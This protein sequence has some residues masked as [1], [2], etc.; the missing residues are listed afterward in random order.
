VGAPVGPL[1]LADGQ[2]AGQVAWLLPLAVVGLGIAARGERL[3]RPLGPAHLTLLLWSAWTLTYAIVYSY[4]GGIFHFYYLATLAPPLAALAGIGVTRLWRCAL[5]NDWRRALVPAT[6]LVTAAWQ[7]SVDASALGSWHDLATTL[8]VRQVTGAWPSWLRPALAGGV[9]VAGG[10][11]A[12]VALRPNPSG[13]PRVLSAAALGT[14]LLATLI[15]PAAWALS[16]VLVPGPGV[17]PSADLARLAD[18]ATSE[19]LAR[20][21]QNADAN[22]SRLIRFLEANRG[23]ARYLLATSSAT[24]ASPIIVRT[25][26]AV[27]ARGGFHGL[28]PILTPEKLARMA[29]AKEVRF[30]MLGDL[31]PVSRRM[32]AEIAGRPIADW[33]RANGRLVPSRLWRAGW[34]A[35]M[36]LYDLHPALDL[37]PVTPPS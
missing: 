34:P 33:V 28:D 10:A 7:L 3:A 21:R 2:L 15:L 31:S 17:L 9:L 14:G 13:P 23:G 19:A 36:T 26:Q 5:G 30:V 25:G 12:L 35:A 22:L 16:S 37:V 20:R 29:E 8:D 1:R 27:M 4:S 11:L 32:G 18:D 6:L 24:L